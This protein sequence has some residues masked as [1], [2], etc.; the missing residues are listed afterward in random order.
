MVWWGCYWHRC[1]ACSLACPVVYVACPVH[2]A[3][4]LALSAALPVRP[5]AAHCL[6]TAC[7]TTAT[8]CPPG[9]GGQRR[10]HCSRF[11]TTNSGLFNDMNGLAHMD[12]FEPTV[13][14]VVTV[15]NAVG[16]GDAEVAHAHTGCGALDVCCSGC[17]HMVTELISA[18]VSGARI[19][20]RLL[21]RVLDYIEIQ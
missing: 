1:A 12:P 10:F 16:A 7:C 5:P 21:R 20:R 11:P 6:T 3:V 15:H 18:W 9:H 2:A 13:S 8:H 14:K 4:K 19:H 17:Y